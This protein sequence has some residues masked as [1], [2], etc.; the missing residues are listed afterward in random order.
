M[1]VSV[2]DKVRFLNEVGGGVVTSKKN[3]QLV[4]VLQED[5]F[6]VPMLI[7]ELVVIE[8]AGG[9]K[10]SAPEKVKDASADEVY[11][12]EETDEGEV[13]KLVFAYV[14]ENIKEIPGD[15]LLLYLVNDCNFFVNFHLGESIK[16]KVYPV[17]NGSIEPNTKLLIDTYRIADLD[18]IG[19]FLIQAVAF[20]KDKPFA[21]QPLIQNEMK[22]NGVKLMKANSYSSNDYFHEPAIVHSLVEDPF[23]KKINEL[24]DTEIT[25]QIKIK[26]KRPRVKNYQKANP[27]NNIIEVD[28]H[29]HELVDST[30]GMSNADMLNLQ[31][32]TFRK[33]LNEN[34]AKKGQKIVF[35]HGVG[36]GTLKTDLRKEIEKK[37]KYNYQ[38]ASFREYGF[39]ATLVIIK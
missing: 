5:G 8:A 29:I 16:N 26:E 32:D 17:L 38:D 3:N 7:T 27:T 21:L 19:S 12:Y 35:I 23:Q 25:E 30:T 36:N 31:L 6:E 13:L 10:V 22:V 18:E 1:S 14:P 20:K 24:T 34:K 4:N 39:G 2:G 37:F 11:S 15:K 9:G 28:L 33:V